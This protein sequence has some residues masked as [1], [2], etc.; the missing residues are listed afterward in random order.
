MHLH[1]N[2]V[3][4]VAGDMFVAAVLDALPE[5]EPELSRA[6]VR[7]AV[8]RLARIRFH[9]YGDGVLTGSRFEVRP[10][11]MPGSHTHRSFREIRA[12]LEDDD[13]EARVASR[14]IA[15]FTLLAEAEGAV[16][17]VQPEAVT[18]HEVGAWDTGSPL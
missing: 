14:A 4:G 10:V 15:I 5:L 18:F 2:P 7:S 17:G 11:E 9:A 6:F 8:S 12:L 1:L 16:H 13:L 3:G